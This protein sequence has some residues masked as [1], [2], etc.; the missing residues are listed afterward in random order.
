MAVCFFWGTTYLGIRVAVE[1]VPP[2]YMISVRYIISGA[3]LL[4]AAAM[5]GAR[6]P[7]GRELLYTAV[8][9]IICIG[10]GNGFL[11]IVEQ[12][13]P[14]GLAALFYTTSPF[15]MVGIDA[16]LP[17][18]KRPRGLTVLGLLI[19]IGG[20]AYLVLPEARAQGLTGSSMLGFLLLQVSGIG[21]ALGALLQKRVH[22][23]SAPLVN[24]AVQQ[25]AAGLA[26]GVPAMFL[27]RAPHAVSTRSELAVAYLVVFGSIVGF[28]SFIYSM[29]RLPVAIVSIY[30]FVN[31]LVAVFLGWM[32]LNEHVGYREFVAMG[33]I[34]GGI[35]VVRWGEASRKNMVTVPSPE[36]AGAVSAAD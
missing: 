2:L 11:A 21:W 32:M 27:E 24:G 12:W 5:G 35:A 14:S 34:F 9:G 10:I 36:E 31:P 17:A 8:C 30:T 25:L 22:T 16:L 28:S 4:V 6:L 23:Q 19:G 1:T 18:G 29:A 7:K 3:I 20:V 33:I 13:I 15:W 26:V